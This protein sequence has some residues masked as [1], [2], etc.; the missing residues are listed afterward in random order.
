MKHFFIFLFV[1]YSSLSFSQNKPFGIPFIKNY[2][3]KE[4]KA[5]T[6]N[7]TVIKD[8]RGIMYFG[9]NDGVLEYDG[10]N[11]N[12]IK[13]KAITR[14]LAVDSSGI[15]YVGADNE[16]GFIQADDKGTLYYTSLSDS[17]D[18]ENKDFTEISSLFVTDDGIYFCSSKKIYK[19]RNKKLS[20]IKLNRGGFVS[21]YINNTLY[22]GDYYLGLQ[23]IVN[24]S[25]ILCK[26]GS[27]YA[28][29]DIS[30]II[31]YGENELLIST[32]SNNIYIYNT[33]TGKSE[34]PNFPAFLNFENLIKES[35]LYVNSICKTKSGF[36]INTLWN[37]IILTNNQFEII[38]H[39][40][41][42]SGLQDETVVSNYSP[43][44]NYTEPTWFGLNNGIAKIELNTPLQK[45]PDNLGLSE[46]VND[47]FRFNNEIYFASNSGVYKL[48]YNKTSD[49]Y[50]FD[51][52]KETDEDQSWSFIKIGKHLISTG[53]FLY[54][55]DG[56]SVITSEI[57]NP[58]YKLIPYQNSVY[59]AQMTGLTEYSFDGKNFRLKNKIKGIKNEILK[60]AADSHNNIWLISNKNDLI[61]FYVNGKDTIADY[62]TEENGFE[63]TYN[64]FFFKYKDKLYFSVDNNLLV[65]DQEK[66]K[67]TE[68]T[69]LNKNLHNSFI[70][71]NDF[72]TDDKSSIYISKHINNFDYIY[73]LTL[74]KNGKVLTDS[75]TFKRLPKMKSNAI[76]PDKNGIV[77]I[78]SSEGIYVYDENI[79]TKPTDSYLTLIRKVVNKDSVLFNGTYFVNGKV[80]INQ[81]KSLIPVLDYKNNS[82]KF[83]FAAP[84]FIQE[85]QT[86]FYTFLEGYD[87]K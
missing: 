56:K 11:W 55:I 36:L 73:K 40:T 85:N 48:N 66:N 33:Q 46:E 51:I 7:W 45:I 30:G 22:S 81:P 74:Q 64:L 3:I 67:L 87:K 60:L 18:E 37:G 35:K 61:R 57:N 4:Y 12:L 80:M 14:S 26:N 38:G 82:V 29:Q 69:E 20:V 15:I 39:Y 63:K 34:K 68:E 75:T 10:V 41:K 13:I 78:A 5:G 49:S 50:K 79:N 42:Q 58:T 17:L 9:N 43:A 70:S 1:I 59:A 27:F 65:Y 24:D 8:R 76:Y 21:F 77:W 86:K 16:F 83:H 72:V 52:I 25:L 19:Y 53:Y 32:Q 2:N 47:I 71:I 31:P 23:K 84:Y 28:G 44:C 54:N 62:M 6:T